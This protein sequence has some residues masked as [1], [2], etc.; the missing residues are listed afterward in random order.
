MTYTETL[1]GGL[2]TVVALYFLARRLGIS[3]YW[4]AVLSGGLPF[5]AYLG[6][7]MAHGFEGDVLAIHLAV[8]I[9]AAGVLGVFGGM[10][11]NTGRMH[12]APKLLIAFFATLAVFNALLLSIAMHGVPDFV[13]DWFVPNSSRHTK[14]HSGFPGALPHDRNKLYEPHMQRIEQ[15]RKLGWSFELE[16]FDALRQGVASKVGLVAKDRQGQPLLGARVTL[17]LWRLANSRDDRRVQLDPVGEGRYATTLHLTNAGKWMAEIY[18]ERAQET[19][20]FQRP[21]VVAPE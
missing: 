9:A 21:F 3:N 10:R 14:I 16:G 11:R 12:W 19:Y 18:V 2:L 1:F 13:F 7:S 20:L 8:F 4:A 17:N 6:L 5:L 15:Q